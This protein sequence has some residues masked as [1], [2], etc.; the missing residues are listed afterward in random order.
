MKYIESVFGTILLNHLNF[1]AHHLESSIVFIKNFPS[2]IGVNLPEMIF[3]TINP[4]QALGKPKNVCCFLNQL[5]M[6]FFS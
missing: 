2:L 6:Q 3:L 4:I 1:R 5:K